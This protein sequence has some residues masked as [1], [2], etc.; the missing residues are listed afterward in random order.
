MTYQAMR[1]SILINELFPEQDL[2]QGMISRLPTLDLAFIPK[3]K[4]HI[5]ILHWNNFN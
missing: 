5:I 3:R 1:Q 4:D 2:V